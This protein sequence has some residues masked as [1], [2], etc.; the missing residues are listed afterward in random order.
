MRA[1]SNGVAT[2]RWCFGGAVVCRAAAHG[3][4]RLSGTE[5]GG[6]SR[7]GQGRLI[8]DLVC[9]NDDGARALA[10]GLDGML[11]DVVLERDARAPQHWWLEVAGERWPLT[12]ARV[13]VHRDVVSQA[14]AIIP[15]RRVPWRKRLFWSALLAVLRT[16][17]GRRWVRRRYGV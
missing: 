8:V 5:A 13:F 7:A 2:Q 15:P 14:R 17:A 9:D 10:G 4:W 11:R 12:Q 3:G 16:A 1:E 6:S